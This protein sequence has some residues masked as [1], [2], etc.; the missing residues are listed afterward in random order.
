MKIR[1]MPTEPIHG[2]YRPNSLINGFYRP[3]LL[4]NCFYRPNLLIVG[5]YRPNL[6]IDGFYRPNLLIDGFQR[7][8]LLIDDFYR[9]IFDCSVLSTDFVHR[10]ITLQ[11]QAGIMNYSGY[12]RISV[13]ELKENDREC[14]Q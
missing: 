3:N 6:L 1:S 8:I 12:L 5:F 14:K 11:V 7:L 9:P 10:Q 4:I 13:K 2:F